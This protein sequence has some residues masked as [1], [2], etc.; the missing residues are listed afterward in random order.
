[1]NLIDL[2]FPDI[3]SKNQTQKNPNSIQST[4]MNLLARSPSFTCNSQNPENAKKKKTKSPLSLKSRV[5]S[6]ITAANPESHQPTSRHLHLQI[7]K[8]QKR[9]NHQELLLHRS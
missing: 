4:I 2:D 9:R 6:S 8:S 7:Q 3:S 1:M 5:F